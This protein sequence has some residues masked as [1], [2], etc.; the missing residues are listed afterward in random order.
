TAILEGGE[1]RVGHADPARLARAQASLK[2]N[3]LIPIAELLRSGPKQFVVGHANDQA[4][5]DQYYLTSWAVAFYL[6]FGLEKLRS[7]EM[8]RYVQNLKA[9]GNSE[10]AF[11]GLVGR[12][13]GEFETAFLE[14]LRRLKP[15]GSTAR[16]GEENGN[17]PNERTNQH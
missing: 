8:T 6:T 11:S 10:S 9:G 13:L 4:V 17:N 12:P 16:L 2:A 5:S 3:G 1:L 14:Y 15:N 7:P